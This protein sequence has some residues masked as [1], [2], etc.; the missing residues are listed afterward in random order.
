M[1]IHDAS[2]RQVEDAVHETSL[3]DVEMTAP[4]ASKVIDPFLVAFEEP[5]DADNP[6]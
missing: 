3:R 4:S 5:F 6:K 2:G 1:S